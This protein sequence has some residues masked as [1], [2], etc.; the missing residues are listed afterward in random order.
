MILPIL[1]IN[2]TSRE[3]HIRLRREVID[4]LRAA[5]DKMSELLPNGRD[6]PGAAER[7]D[8]D[9]VRHR[10]RVTLIRVLTAELMA[11]AVTLIDSLTIATQA[12]AIAPEGEAP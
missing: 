5:A 6:Y 4:A 8:A 1:N 11:E 10:A 12:L 7:C 2:G 3:E 9:R